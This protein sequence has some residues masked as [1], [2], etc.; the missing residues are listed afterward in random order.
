M[1]S[2]LGYQYW[3]RC[4]FNGYLFKGYH[5]PAKT[6]MWYVLKASHSERIETQI[7]STNHSNA[8]L[9]LMSELC[10]YVLSNFAN[11]HEQKKCMANQK[12]P[13]SRC[14]NTHTKKSNFH[15]KSTN[16]DVHDPWSVSIPKQIGWTMI[17]PAGATFL[18]QI[19]KI[20]LLLIILICVF[21]ILT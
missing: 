11:A 9:F 18:Y 15:L 12:L 21:F 6:S 3:Q 19:F 4:W 20:L 2:Q 10:F 7:L 1:L 5:C 13:Y 14:V 8:M 17:I 16:C